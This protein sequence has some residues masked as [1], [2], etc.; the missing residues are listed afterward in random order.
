MK[1]KK[2]LIV[3]ET[4]T[5]STNITP[6][7]LIAFG[8]EFIHSELKLLIEFCVQNFAEVCLVNPFAT[9]LNS[10]GDFEVYSITTEKRGRKNILDFHV[11]Y[12]SVTLEKVVGTVLKEDTL[13]ILH[14]KI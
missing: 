9:E 14:T 5:N 11:V 4:I 6:K 12:F 8:N 7:E 2:L 13:F 1:N 3:T 10:I